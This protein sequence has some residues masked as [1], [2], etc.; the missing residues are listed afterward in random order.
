M[1]I[2]GKDTRTWKLLRVDIED[3]ICKY[4]TK[5]RIFFILCG[6]IGLCA[7]AGCARHNYKE[8]SDEEVYKII[9]S[10]WDEEFGSKANYKISDTAPS[11]D[12]IQI[13]K[14]IPD[15]GVLTLPQAIALATAYNRDYH[16]EKEALYIKALDL[17]LTR[18]DFEYQF[19]GGPSASA[20]YREDADNSVL[21]FDSSYGF[22]RLLA[23]GTRISARVASAWVDVLSGNMRDGLTS[24]LDVTITQPLLRGSDRDIVLENLTQAERDTLYQVRSFN[25][26]RKTFVVSIITK[27]Y[28]ILNL[29]DTVRNSKRSYNVL[30][31]LYQ[32]TEPLVDAGRMPKFELDRIH[33]DRLLALDAYVQAQKLY[34]QALDEFKI[35]LSLPT[36]TEFKLD[37]EELVALRAVELNY[38]DFTLDEAIESALRHRLDLVNNADAIIDARRKVNV[39]KDAF[40][41]DLNITGTAFP[42]SRRVADRSSLASLTEEYGVVLELDLPLDREV[43][44]NI[45]RKALIT[46]NRSLRDYEQASDTVALEIRQ[47][48]RDLIEGAQRHRV[49]TESFQS[50]RKRFQDTFLLLQYGRASS[51]RVLTA[52]QDYFEAQ[53]AATDALIGYV[54]STLNFYRD[55]GVLYVRPDGM[56]ER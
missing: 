40:R 34:K 24:I 10:K 18:Y 8:E 27:Y 39:A 46:L 50:A 13:E 41:S 16:T 53:N 4:F 45:Y 32:R 2:L 22:N 35:D 3:M 12:D 42:V 51:R 20:G 23:G 28:Q 36:T 49:Q 43:E 29:S 54:I 14:A 5:K 21:G 6:L 52:Q 7:F 38:P 37:E 44:K 56:W 17:R 48:Y 25:R 31:W 30:D 9:D 33:Q 15:S 19:F 55:A 11:P 26:Y 1:G 47:A